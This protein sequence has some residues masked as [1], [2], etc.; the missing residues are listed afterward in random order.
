MWLGAR[1]VAVLHSGDLTYSFVGTVIGSNKVVSENR[2]GQEEPAEGFLDA[3]V[4]KAYKQISQALIQGLV[5]LGAQV[6]LGAGQ[7]EYR[8]LND[9]FLAV[10]GA[11]LLANG[12]KLAGSAQLRRRGGVLQHGSIL[13]NQDQFLMSVLLANEDALKK[14][15]HRHTNLY[16]LIEPKSITEIEEALVNGFERQF[17]QSFYLGELTP[18]ELSAAAKTKDR[19]VVSSLELRREPQT[20]P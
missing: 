16:D 6:M 5:K 4:A 2:P 8:N 1:P 15:H 10:T 12:C 3:V 11:D 17:G 7:S 13:L 18:L 20:I 9:C 19:F 14:R